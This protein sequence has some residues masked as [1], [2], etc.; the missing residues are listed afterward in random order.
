MTLLALSTLT[1][2]GAKDTHTR[3]HTHTHIFSVSLFTVCPA[4]QQKKTGFYKKIAYRKKESEKSER[5][6]ESK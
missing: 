4:K 5:E 3:T 2:T 6:R 1:R